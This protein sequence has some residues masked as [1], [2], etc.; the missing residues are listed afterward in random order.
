MR[1]RKREHPKERQ[2]SPIEARLGKKVPPV[3][4]E[5]VGREREI[6]GVMKF[7]H[8]DPPESCVGPAGT[9]TLWGAGSY[10]LTRLREEFHGHLLF[11]S[12]TQHEKLGPLDVVVREPECEIRRDADRRAR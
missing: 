7:A 3:P 2:A 1:Q 10:A 4:A 9:K 12:K 5:S 11:F 6:D 8:C